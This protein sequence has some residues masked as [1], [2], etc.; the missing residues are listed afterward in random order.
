MNLYKLST[1]LTLMSFREGTYFSDWEYDA[2]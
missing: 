2:V 1:V